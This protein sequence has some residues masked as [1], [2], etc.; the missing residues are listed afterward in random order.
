MAVFGDHIYLYGGSIEDKENEHMYRLNM[1]SFVW[2]II[3]PSG[4]L[5]MP[6]DDHSCTTTED[7]RMVIFGGFVKGSR[8]NDI[9]AYDFTNN[10]WECLYPESAEESVPCKRAASTICAV[11]N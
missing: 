10:S 7:N 11:G 1:D 5:P 2:D 9:Y 6:R 4:T 8:S 3:T